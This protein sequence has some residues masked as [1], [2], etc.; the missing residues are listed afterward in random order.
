[1]TDRRSPCGRLPFTRVWKLKFCPTL[2][3][4]SVESPPS[5]KSYLE[6]LPHRVL[7]EQGRLQYGHRD[8]GNISEA[9]VEESFRHHESLGVALE[10]GRIL[11]ETFEL[12]E[13]QF[14]EP[15]ALVS[16]NRAK[17]A[18]LAF[19]S[20]ESR[21]DIAAVAYINEF[22]DFD[23]LELS[24]DKLIGSIIPESIQQLCQEYIRKRQSP[25]AVSL[26]R[27]WAVRD[28]IEGLWNLALAVDQKDPQGAKDEC[29]RRRPNST[30]DPETNWLAVGRAILCADLSA[31]LNP[32]QRNPRLIL[33]EKEGAIV[34]L[35][36]AK[37]VRTALYLT[38]FD[39]I[40][41]KT[42]YRRCPNCDRPFIV[43]VKRKRYC[44]EL[45][46]N[47]AKARRFRDRHK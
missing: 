44:K 5:S 11:R 10:A 40:V 14:V 9:Q 39:M 12:D 20:L 15:V 16:E 8:R 30:F 7:L 36:M 6:T 2:S 19:L 45:C 24:E 34:A 21:N 25:F 27:F 32:Q 1:M 17:E 26:S 33:C 37:T 38:L 22:G 31:S 35:T 47:A 42:E 28:E 23:H 13:Q 4:A 46:Q 43:T 41:S 18:L 29:V 3:S